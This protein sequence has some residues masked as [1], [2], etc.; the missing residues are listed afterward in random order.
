MAWAIQNYATSLTG[1]QTYSSTK[2]HNI[3]T[4]V[5][6]NAAL[7]TLWN[8]TVLCKVFCFFNCLDPNK[9]GRVKETQG[10]EIQ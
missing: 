7:S 1:L 9:E 6:D 3:Q 4:S 10:Q 8:A 2:L 5:F